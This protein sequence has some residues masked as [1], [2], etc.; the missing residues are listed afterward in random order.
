MKISGYILAFLLL[1]SCYFN[2]E[3][4]RDSS[5]WKYATPTSV[6]LNELT[7]LELDNDLR[8]GGFD[9]IRGVVA[10]KDNKLVFENYYEGDE[11]GSLQFLSGATISVMSILTGIALDRGYLDSIQTPINVFFPDYTAIFDLEPIKNDITVEHLLLMRSGLAWYETGSP[12]LNQNN[13]LNGLTTSNDWIEYALSR[14]VDA[15]P[16]LRYA[17]NS[18]HGVLLAEILAR[19][20]GKS[21][22]DFADEVLFEPLDIISSDWQTDAFGH[23]NGGFGLSIPLMDFAKLGYL[24]INEGMW[25]GQRIVSEAWINQSTEQQFRIDRFSDFA[26]SWH[27][28]SEL[29]SFSAILPQ[30]DTFFAEG[31]GGQYLFVVPHQNFVLAVTADNFLENDWTPLVIYRDFFAQSIQ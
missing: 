17:Y 2:E 6:G 22:V 10:V 13:S 30:N 18:S 28:F 25:E 11:R 27:L 31:A 20:S 12:I 8:E 26:Y 21:F 4:I 23:V 16:G 7:L 24:F 14:D 19:A 9:R 15:T 5:P 1:S 3:E 29:S